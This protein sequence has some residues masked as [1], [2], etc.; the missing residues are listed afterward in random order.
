[1]AASYWVGNPND[2]PSEL[3]D[4]L[5]HVNLNWRLLWPGWKP[6]KGGQTLRVI[7]PEPAARIACP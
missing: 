1:V 7:Q 5:L 3:V 6:I 4:S 2:T